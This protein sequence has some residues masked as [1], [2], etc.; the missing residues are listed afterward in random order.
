MNRWVVFVFG[1]IAGAAAIWLAGGAAPGASPADPAPPVAAA[2]VKSADRPPAAVVAAARPAA[3]IPEA[4][5]GMVTF[6]A[7]NLRNYLKMERR[8]GSET[9]ADQPKPE[10]E[11]APL[12]AM[13]AE[14]KPDIIGV[15][16]I[17]EDADLADLQRRLA[18]AGHELRVREWVDSADSYRNLGL[19]SRFPITARNHRTDLT[20][21]LG[22]QTMPFHRGLLD[23]SVDPAPGYRLRLVGTHL[24]SKRDVPEGDQEEM[25]RNEAR[26]LRAHVDDILKTAPETNL[27][28]YGDLND[29]KNTAAFQ[30]IKGPSGSRALYDI[31]LKDFEGHTWTHFWSYADIYS[32]IDYILVSRGLMPEV[33]RNRSFIHHAPGWFTASDH[34]PL[35]LRLRPQ[36]RRPPSRN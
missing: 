21:R 16:E 1:L 8:V 17:G 24:K 19:L 23:C 11:I 2:P 22:N 35:V 27:L 3:A 31:W 32:R 10:R 20:Y 14:L 25:R 33:E 30:D 15:C 36:E 9:L 6:V 18:A 29:T 4:E 28:V 13:L 12:V 7:H 26:L 5:P 34:R